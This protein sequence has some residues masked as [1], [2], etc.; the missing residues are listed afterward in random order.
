VAD[1]EAKFL[2]PTPQVDTQEVKDV[3]QG[4]EE[5]AL[6]GKDDGTPSANL[7]APEGIPLPDETS[8]E[9]DE[10]TSDPAPSSLDTTPSS[11]NAPPSSLDATSTSVE[12][13]SKVL[14]EQPTT[15]TSDA[16]SDIASSDGSDD[17]PPETTQNP[18]ALEA[19]TPLVQ[20]ASSGSNG[21]T[22]KE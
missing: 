3:T 4:V 8:G 5:V 10:P 9:L 20:T 11:F 22:T 16:S 2:V 21:D 13:S 7:V 19:S 18:K 12:E 15:I 1:A 17:C 6:D 14:A